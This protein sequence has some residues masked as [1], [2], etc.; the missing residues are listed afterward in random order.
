MAD[1]VV[2]NWDGH[3]YQARVFWVRA[4]ELRRRDKIHVVEVSYETDGPKGFDD[5][6]VRYLPA[7]KGRRS[8]EI[9]AEHYQVKFHVNEGGRFGYA[10]LI[11]PE[12]IG[13]TK[14]SFLKRLRDAVRRSPPGSTFWLIT[15]DRIRD[16]APLSELFSGR[17]SSLDVDK[18]RVGKTDGSR[19]GAVRALWREHLELDT[20]EE[21]YEIL[22]RLHIKHGAKNLEEMRDEVDSAFYTANLKGG[23]NTWEFSLDGVIKGLK[24][25]GKN[26]FTRDEFEAFVRERGWIRTDDDDRHPVTIRSFGDAWTGHLSSPSESDLSLLDMFDERH[27]KPG[28]DWSST[29][30]PEVTS[31]LT[32][33]RQ[34]H[35]RIRLTL[36]AH[37]TIAFLAGALLHPKSGVDVEV[38]QKGRAPTSIW[39]ADDQTSG[40]GFSVEERVLG[41]GPDVALVVSLARTALPDVEDHVQRHP[42]QIGKILHFVPAAGHGQSSVR[43]GEH[44]AALADQIADA[45]SDLRLRSPTKVHVFVAGPNAFSFFLGQHREALGNVVLYEYDFGDTRQYQ[46]SFEIG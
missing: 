38:L 36:E 15:I 4:A 34:D 6:V 1:A 10:D 33:V 18:L 21:L 16:D 27:L 8:F 23:A 17:D 13:A 31:F 30:Q 45:I 2:A 5:V 44:A 46:P 42:G 19:M 11:E 22:D 24:A 40:P 39:R 26:R 9:A 32:K 41:D 28:A 25:V 29:V 43:G 35:K 20:D 37:A 14:V 12:F 7:R 3:D